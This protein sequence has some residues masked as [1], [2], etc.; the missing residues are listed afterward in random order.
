M[1]HWKKAPAK[2][3]RTSKIEISKI[4]KFII[5][6]YTADN[7][8][9]A[10]K[11]KPEQNIEKLPKGEILKSS[12][13]FIVVVFLNFGGFFLVNKIGTRAIENKREISIKGSYSI[14][15]L[16]FNNR[17]PIAKPKKVMNI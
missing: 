5:V 17:F 9:I 12:F 11:R 1:G 3:I 7:V 4:D 2:V 15:L 8:N 10:E 14:G 16:I 13:T 6:A